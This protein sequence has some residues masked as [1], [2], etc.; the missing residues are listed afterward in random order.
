MRSKRCIVDTRDLGI[1][2]YQRV[3]ICMQ[4]DRNTR[5]IHAEKSRDTAYNDTTMHI[6]M[7]VVGRGLEKE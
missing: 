5:R 7:D 2:L 3:G 4:T 1:W 6:V